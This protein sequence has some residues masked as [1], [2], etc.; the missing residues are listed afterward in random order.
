M[1]LPVEIWTTIFRNLPE[2]DVLNAAYAVPFW[3]NIVESHLHID[4]YEQKM[5]KIS[6]R[7]NNRNAIS[8]YADR[9]RGLPT[10]IA[11]ATLIEVCRNN[12]LEMAKWLDE[13]YDF[14]SHNNI[15]LRTLYNIMKCACKRGHIDFIKWIVS[16]FDV[17]YGM[18][19][20]GN[21]NLFDLSWSRGHFE[22]AM[23]LYDVYDLSPD[24]TNAAL[25]KACRENNRIVL[26]WFCTTFV[27]EDMDIRENNN[28][29]LYVACHYGSLACLD[30]IYRTLCKFTSEDVEM[31]DSRAFYA[32]CMQNHL[33]VARWLVDTVKFRTHDIRRGLIIEVDEKGFPEC[34]NWLFYI[35]YDYIFD[36]DVH[37]DDNLLLRKICADDDWEI[38]QW[39]IAKFG[40]QP[41][42]LRA[43]NNEAIRG[44]CELGNISSVN[45]YLYYG[46]TYNDVATNHNEGFRRAC[47]KGHLDL[48]QWMFRMFPEKHKEAILR[49]VRKF[50]TIENVHNGYIREYLRKL[51]DL[52]P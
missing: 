25:V 50:K 15:G 29:V 39:L 52:W 36:G 35:F 48:V 42:D 19:V 21:S 4:E 6:A 51:L 14:K 24:N 40:L 9:I 23:W 26:A 31:E 20:S 37:R 45:N 10:E 46:L 16:V 5:L 18:I 22:I 49:D 17:D 27:V 11:R 44:A 47:I 1:S 43:N 33:E 28:E 41:D 8:Y 13:K 3:N 12:N 34:V 32:C 2:S 7:Y 30:Y 38:I